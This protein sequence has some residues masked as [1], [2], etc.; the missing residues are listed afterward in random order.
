MEKVF[1]SATGNR[2][3]VWRLRIW[4]VDF[5]VGRTRLHCTV[6]PAGSTFQLLNS[7]ARKCSE[8]HDGRGKFGATRSDAW[9]TGT[10]LARA[11]RG[12]R[13]HRV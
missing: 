4:L 11:P 6:V 9:L 2:T 8:L 5:V 12:T 7:A 3:R 13:Q 1:G 10:A